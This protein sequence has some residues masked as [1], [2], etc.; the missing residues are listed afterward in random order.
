VRTLGVLGALFVAFLVL[1]SVFSWRKLRAADEA[2]QVLLREYPAGSPA[3]DLFSRAAALG[4]ATLTL[5]DHS[6]K[7]YGQDFFSGD[8]GVQEMAPSELQKKL[9]SAPHAA[10]KAGIS[11]YYYFP[12][13]WGLRW[14]VESGLIK[15]G[16]TRTAD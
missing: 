2:V 4:F 14:E 12:V 5:D 6:G 1:T 10:A 7:V 13:E 11:P 8:G 9:E 3:K 16:P 15:T